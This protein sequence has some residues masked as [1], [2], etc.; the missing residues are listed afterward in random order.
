MEYFDPNQAN[1]I[2]KNNSLA[3]DDRLTRPES[4]LK[5]AKSIFNRKGNVYHD[6]INCLFSWPRI[7]YGLQNFVKSCSSPVL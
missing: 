7:K 2:L 3:L 5:V 4:Q 6:K 1:P